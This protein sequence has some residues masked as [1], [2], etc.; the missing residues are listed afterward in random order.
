MNPP[1]AFFFTI[2]TYGTW[3]PGD[4]R[5]TVDRDHNQ[6]GAPLLEPD[7]QR[8]NRSRQ[9]M[10]FPVLLL[11]PKMRAA[12]TASIQDT[13]RFHGWELFEVAVRTNHAHLIV[14]FADQPPEQMLQKLKARATRALHEQGLLDQDRPLWVSGPGS[15]KYLWTESDISDAATYVREHQDEPR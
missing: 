5:G 14:E 8:A 2:R 4:E 12:V 6:Y 15:R 3:L 11:T 1:L 10:R 7:P 13:C 9:T